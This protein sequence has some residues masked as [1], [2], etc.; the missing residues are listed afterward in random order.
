VLA[1]SLYSG[2]QSANLLLF[3]DNSSFFASFLFFRLIFRPKVTSP[4]AFFQQID[5]KTTGLALEA[6]PVDYDD[7]E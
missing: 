6:S 5:K 4:L 2:F 3:V 7:G 1:S